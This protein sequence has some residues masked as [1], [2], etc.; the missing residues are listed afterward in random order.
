MRMFQLQIM[1]HG[2]AGAQLS[3]YYLMI[4]EHKRVP[5]RQLLYAS[6]VRFTKLGNFSSDRT[7]M[8][9]FFFWFCPMAL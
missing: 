2:L 4:R 3:R 7:E 8:S 9:H 6:N 5:A 1:L